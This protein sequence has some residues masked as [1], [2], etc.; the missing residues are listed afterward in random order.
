MSAEKQARHTGGA[1][2]LAAGFGRRFGSDKRAHT[3]A[4]GMTLLDATLDRYAEVYSHLCVVLRPDDEALARHV[5]SLPG[6]P[7]I[8]LSVDAE[9]GM[10]H[11]LAA[12]VRSIADHWQWVSVALADMPFV[13]ATTLNELLDAFFA[14]RAERIVQPVYKGT[15]GHPVT[16]PGR[17]FEQ[18][19]RL[20]GDAGARSVLRNADG[21]IRT[22]VADPGVLED[23]DTPSAAERLR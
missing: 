12:G 1:L 17:Y 22:P 18:L 6:N 11:S 10:G 9:L 15:P 4:D 8:A 2:I 23:V 5:R 21:L 14:A 20:G 7:E 19:S 13:S 3:L 16:F